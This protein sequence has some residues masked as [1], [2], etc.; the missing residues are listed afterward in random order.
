MRAPSPT[1]F[2]FAGARCAL[3]GGFQADGGDR[4]VLAGTVASER[5]LTGIVNS[6]ESFKAA[7]SVDRLSSLDSQ[8]TVMT[9]GSSLLLLLVDR[10]GQI[11]DC[12]S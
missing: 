4:L 10:L 3:L 8:E 6:D 5:Q 2:S 1:V 11:A 12:R 9:I 7:K